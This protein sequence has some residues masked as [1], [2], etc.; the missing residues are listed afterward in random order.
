MN[1]SEIVFADPWHKQKDEAMTL[2]ESLRFICAYDLNIG[3]IDTIYEL[4]FL[5]RTKSV[6]ELWLITRLS[7]DSIKRIA[8]G[9]LLPHDVDKD[10]MGV[11]KVFAGCVDNFV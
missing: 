5:H 2:P 11:E 3:G 4:A 6:D 10:R 7:L 8:E 9:T 1:N